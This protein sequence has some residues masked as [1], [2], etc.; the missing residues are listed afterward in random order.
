M[1]IRQT[2]QKDIVYCRRN[3]TKKGNVD[4]KNRTK[5]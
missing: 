3:R 2:E 1:Q 5:Q 4:R